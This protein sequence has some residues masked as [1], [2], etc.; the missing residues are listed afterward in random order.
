[1]HSTSSNHRTGVECLCAYT[2]SC[3]GHLMN[4]VS[5]SS[6]QTSLVSR[7]GGMDDL[8]GNECDRTIDCVR[9]QRACFYCAT[10][11]RVTQYG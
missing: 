7:P 4:Q 9:S 1:M 2:V 8:V 3:G 5:A 10:C 6:S 11:A